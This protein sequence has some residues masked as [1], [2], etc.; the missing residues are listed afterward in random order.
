MKIQK[1]REISLDTQVPDDND[2]YV[3]ANGGLFEITDSA[4]EAIHVANEQKGVVLNRDQQYIWERGNQKTSFQLNVEDVPQVFLNGT[5][6]RQTIEEELGDRFELLDLT[7]GDLEEILYEISAQRAILAKTS[8]DTAVVI[9][10]Y[11]EYNT[12]LYHPDTGKTEPYGM[13]DSRALFGKAGNVFF[14]YLE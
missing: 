1:E 11:D 13:N 10:G 12:W 2:Y 6:D 4:A 8:D 9:V 7:G 14:S 3:Y 5:V